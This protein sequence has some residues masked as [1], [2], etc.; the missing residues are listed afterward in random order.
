GAL[1]EESVYGIDADPKSR[2]LQVMLDDLL[3]RRKNHLQRRLVLRRFEVAIQRVE[4]PER[5]I[6]GVIDTF[7]L[8]IR[9]VVRNEPVFHVMSES[10]KHP[11]RFGMTTGGDRQPLERDHRVAP[12]IGE[13]M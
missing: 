6:G 12:P 5:G 10:A 7:I 8:P 9:K 11:S 13:P 2:A 4:E 3:Q 1:A